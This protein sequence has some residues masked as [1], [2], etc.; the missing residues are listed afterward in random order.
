MA[1][2]L[3]GL[4]MDGVSSIEFE[5]AGPDASIVTRLSNGVKLVLFRVKGS[6]WDP[7]E[8][9]NGACGERFDGP[10]VG[11]RRQMVIRGPQS[12]RRSC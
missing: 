9:W 10:K 5:Y 6:V 12:P 3:A 7:C 1:Q 2:A 11:P 4:D 8:Y